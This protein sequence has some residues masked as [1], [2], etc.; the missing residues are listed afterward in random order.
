MNKL[1][2]EIDQIVDAAR[3]DADPINEHNLYMSNV[4]YATK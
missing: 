1:V 2:W 3:G 4:T